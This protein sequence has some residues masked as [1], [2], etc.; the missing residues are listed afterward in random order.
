MHFVGAIT[1]LAVIWDL[2]DVA[3]SIVIWPNLIALILL[4]PIVVAE[5]RSYFERKPWISNYEKRQQLKRE[6]RL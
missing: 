4:T 2:A 3:L 5:T 1:T 6:G